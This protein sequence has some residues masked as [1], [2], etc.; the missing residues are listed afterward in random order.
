MDE[1]MSG[2]P[3][4]PGPKVLF[5]VQHLLGI[6]HIARASR[7]AS[8]MKDDGFDVTVVTGGLPVPGFPADG[9][10]AIA[11]PPVVASN[12]GFSGLADENGQPAD[13][14]FLARRRDQLLEIFRRL[15]PDMVIIE[16]FP[17]GRRQMRFE[18]I[19]LIE[20]IEN[21]TPRPKLITSVRDI[22][23]QRT[24]PGRN[25]E[26]VALI[27]A[28][29]DR[30][31]VHGDEN[32]VPL[33]YSFPLAEE[34]ADHIVHTGLVAAPPAPASPEKFDIV[35]SA[36]GGAVGA[37]LVN[38][39]IGAARRHTQRSWCVIAGPNLP[40]AD[41]QKLLQDSPSNVEVVR[42]RKDFPSLLQGAEISVSQAG[43]NTVCDL[44]QAGCRAILVPFTQGGETEQA[45][46][47]E[48][49]E[50]M[51]LA[52]AISEDR[53][54]VQVLSD[55]IAEALENP[56]PPAAALDLDG[57]RKTARY[58]RSLR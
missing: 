41:F 15:K 49:L 48:R 54:D 34:I 36:G 2:S 1:S 56:P 50:E 19:P 45:V 44:L 30:V 3:E 23:Q 13:E 35:V 53:L 51:G 58:L 10:P 28:H 26:T 52:I 31:L 46:R 25:E 5:Y 39:A 7:I 14:A 9:I 20:A 16:A 37:A 38:A 4:T 8:A 33:S 57:A 17:F 6:G 32:F 27:K 42:F 11:L 22:V 21:S 12:A 43:Y 47:A 29:F 24:K 40:G 55:A 18:L